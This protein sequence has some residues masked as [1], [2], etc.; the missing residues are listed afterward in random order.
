[1]QTFLQSAFLQALG[2]AIASSL[3][4]VALLWLIVI[5]IKNI[6]RLSSS[7]KYFVAI[8][9]E[10]AAF[11]WFVSTF[12][13]YYVKC[14]EVLSQ[15]SSTV[16]LND[17]NYVWEPTVNDFSSAVL[18]Y[19]IKAE[20]LLPYLSVAYLCI[21]LFLV[22]RLSR[23][24]YFTQ[25]IRTQGLQKP[26]VEWKLFVKRTAAY[27]GIKKE[28]KIYFS[29]LIK[30]P[31]TLGFLKPLIL[32]PVASINHLTTD[33]LEALLLHELAHIK[34]ADYLIN[35]IQSIIEIV[36]FFNPFVQLLGRQIKKE[37]EN[38]CDDWVLQF[39]YN[40][41]MYAEALLRIACIPSN[42]NFAMR[43]AGN[44]ND[45]LSRVKRMLNKQEKSYSYRNQVFALLLITIM[46]ATVA[47]FNPATKK[48]N[49]T[50]GKTNEATHR[51]IV[52]PLSASVD[53]P[54]FNPI[55]FF[56]KP[57]QEK[58]DKAL[59]EA[60]AKV[61]DAAPVI[62]EAASNILTSVTPI[63]LEKLQ[64][65]HVDLNDA[66]TE[67]KEALR[68]VEI[69]KLQTASAPAFS[70]DSATIVDA[71]KNV[72]L[73]TLNS[74]TE[75]KEVGADIQK[76]QEE[77][78]KLTKD[79]NWSNGVSA[80]ISDAV[81][82]T[83][84]QLSKL[85]VDNNFT[86][87]FQNA[88][89]AIKDN[90]KQKIDVEKM[91][92]AER[93]MKEKIKEGSRKRVQRWQNQIVPPAQPKE[94]KTYSDIQDEDASVLPYINLQNNYNVQVNAPANIYLPANFND[95]FNYTY[96]YIDSINT[97]NSAIIVVK[98][99]PANDSSYTK[100]ITVEITGNNGVHKCYEFTVE[101]CQ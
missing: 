26:D 79:N 85:K 39:Q 10:F 41:A 13:Y 82:S 95:N 56:S 64:N 78:F 69:G 27:L 15:V 32:V 48:Y 88:L 11:V 100:R 54:L 97:L 17:S 61:D 6:G 5:V 19:T 29:N 90:V 34:R 81:K 92:D 33:Q 31:V 14:S 40:P 16:S 25:K 50:V 12:R 89:D 57:L 98:H 76:A 8:I 73:N 3:W 42:A 24:F 58:L 53:N 68:N 20:Q 63:A 86:L 93:K 9:A 55:Y 28:V 94:M 22:I 80:Q 30:S 70:F 96:N 72:L 84:D 75:W 67:T 7:S 52:E 36:L 99:N 18:Y 38:S 37:R 62:E 46:L 43:A 91:K 59:D 66:L 4:Q 74:T 65:L 44:K 1:M 47:W 87:I 101:V 51:V 77:V 35:I 49:S 21:L 2:Y 45:L 83:A 23:A 60:N 71:A